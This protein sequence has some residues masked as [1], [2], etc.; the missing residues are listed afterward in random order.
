MINNKIHKI[1][2]KYTQIYTLNILI[3]YKILLHTYILILIL[4]YSILSLI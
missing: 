3:I 1:Y 4:F 2:Y